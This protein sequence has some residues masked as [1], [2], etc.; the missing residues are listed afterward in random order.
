M[1]NPKKLSAYEPYD[2]GRIIGRLQTRISAQIVDTVCAEP[3]L[4]L[5]NLK[6]FKDR[7]SSQAQAAF[8]T[9]FEKWKHS[10]EYD[11]SIVVTSLSLTPCRS[12]GAGIRS[13]PAL[14]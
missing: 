11:V 9:C 4:D 10:D 5:V 2:V 6:A 1:V 14:P 3:I 13:V 8:D 7:I 12:C